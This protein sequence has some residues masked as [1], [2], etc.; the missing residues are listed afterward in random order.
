MNSRI[1]MV[2]PAR[3]AASAA[4]CLLAVGVALPATASAQNKRKD[5]SS[6][7]YV[8][9]VSGEAVIDTGEAIEDLAK[10][11]VYTAQGAV[12]ETKRPDQES[13]R[14]KF[15]ST[16]VYSNGTGAFFD[17]DTRVEVRRFMQ[18]PFTPN[19]TDM[20]VEP[21]ISQ[22]QAFVARGTVGL[23]TSKLV[24]GSNMGYQTP[25]GSVSI[26]GKKSVIEAGQ[27]QTKI[28]MLE[29]ESTVKAGPQDMGGHVL[30]S[31]EQAIISRDPNGG[32]NRI[33]I[34]RIPANEIAALDDKVAMA[35][36]AKKSV[37]FE[38]RE[39]TV[40]DGQATG[41]NNNV[42][43]QGNSGESGATDGGTTTSSSAGTPVT[44]FDGTTSGGSGIVI[45][46][47]VP[48]EILPVELPVQFTVSP[49]RLV[50]V[51]PPGS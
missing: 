42:G 25:H 15:F 51:T 48:V 45:R 49:A 35:C 18:E 46:E 1:L 10:R 4:L 16:M 50:T 20:D 29:G 11:S 47:I 21:S 5:P 23:C 3:S 36:M 14:S 27:N 30:K 41:S 12:I 31:G 43:D 34:T 39:R 17:A 44:A 8:T 32:P 37:Y 40:T 7:V 28:S 13:D 24:S 38:V 6:K 26:R 33:E 22:T 19:R 9:D 2:P